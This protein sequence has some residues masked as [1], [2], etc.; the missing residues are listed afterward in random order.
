VLSPGTEA[1]WD[2]AAHTATC[3]SCATSLERGVAG[4]SAGRRYERLHEGRERRVRTR[5]GRLSGLFL[6]FSSDPQ[7]TRAWATGSSGE[8]RLGA[9]L[10]S[11]DDDVSRIVLHDRRIPGTRTNI[12]HIAI[13]Q[14]GVFVIDAKT[15]TGKVRKI[16]KGSWFSTDVRLYVGRRDRSQLVRDMARQVEAVRNALGE[17]AIAEFAVPV[18]PVL[19]FVAVEWP[20]FAR[21]FQIEGVWIER[22]ESLGRRLRAPG[23]L[24][25]E[26]IRTLAR[27]VA[28]ALP[29]A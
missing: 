14:G 13:T 15:Y 1:I 17:P 23:P 28:V 10:D 25:G 27:K 26:H 8:R 5:R 11:L 2:G 21:P 22:P 7:S 18:V 20:W 4:A 19:C 16:D 29:V 12:D 24:A 3:L 6:A 9:Y